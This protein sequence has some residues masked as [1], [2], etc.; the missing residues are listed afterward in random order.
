MLKNWV[1]LNLALSFT[2]IVKFLEIPAIS[3]KDRPRWP[4]PK[5]SQF[6]WTW[7]CISV[8]VETR[9]TI[10]VTVG[11][12]LMRHWIQHTIVDAGRR[13]FGAIIYLHALHKIGLAMFMAWRHPSLLFP[14][15]LLPLKF[16][17]IPTL[18]EIFYFAVNI[19]LNILC[20]NIQ[21]STLLCPGHVKICENF[22]TVT[23]TLMGSKYGVHM[24]L[25]S[26]FTNIAFFGWNFVFDDYVNVHFYC[27]L[28][29]LSLLLC[30]HSLH[31]PWL[32]TEGSGNRTEGSGLHPLWSE[33]VRRIGCIVCCAETWGGTSR[34]W[35]IILWHPTLLGPLG[36]PPLQHCI[37]PCSPCQ[38]GSMYCGPAEMMA[39][40][41]WRCCGREGQLF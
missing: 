3:R 38:S 25:L 10:K 26:D 8:Q 18:L 7:W 37:A 1:F 28:Q 23:Q 19:L 24:S 5:S 33:G 29:N 36:S 39:W 4:R 20:I 40:S 6:S 32:S 14:S 34:A 21:I 30:T 41:V 11:N 12:R 27:L 22:V 31:H 16:Q 35:D 17:S 13:L 15:F 9:D 2:K